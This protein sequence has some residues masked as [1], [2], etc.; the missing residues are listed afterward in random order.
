M[1]ES[2]GVLDGGFFLATSVAAPAVSATRRKAHPKM[3]LLKVFRTILPPFPEP[4]RHRERM[5]PGNRQQWELIVAK[6]YH[7]PILASPH[8]FQP[9][10][11]IPPL[12]AQ[13]SRAEVAR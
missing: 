6:G 12:C 13:I 9:P 5:R 4:Y 3:T 2:A 1:P 11:R 8:L 7:S 10:C